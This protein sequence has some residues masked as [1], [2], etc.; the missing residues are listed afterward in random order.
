MRLANSTARILRGVNSF[1]SFIIQK[2]LGNEK[3][4]SSATDNDRDRKP[5]M[6]LS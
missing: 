1:V 2:R 5:H 4:S 3:C 6:L